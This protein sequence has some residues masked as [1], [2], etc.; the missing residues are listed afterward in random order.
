M[1]GLVSA[2]VYCPSDELC[3]KRHK[4]NVTIP[5]M[6]VCMYVYIYGQVSQNR[7]I[8][9]GSLLTFAKICIGDAYAH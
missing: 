7:R 3:H 6:Y 4:G 8:Y 2:K 9:F 1:P 5:C